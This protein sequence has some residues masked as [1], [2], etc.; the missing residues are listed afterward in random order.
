M[1]QL[2]PIHPRCIGTTALRAQLARLGFRTTPRTI[3][4]DLI[5]L[6]TVF[7]I[8]FDPRTRPYAWRWSRDADP[9]P[10]PIAIAS[11]PVRLVAVVTAS[12][13]RR[14]GEVE[15]RPHGDGRTCVTMTVSGGPA[16]RRWVLGFGAG[17][18]VLQ[19]ASLRDELRAEA[20]AAAARYA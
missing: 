11:T 20:L 7:P 16:L 4:R 6:Q 17:F 18:E 13:L 19:P 12:V 3:Q 5:A 10:L 9:H 15:A 8:E 1:L 14:L 2:L